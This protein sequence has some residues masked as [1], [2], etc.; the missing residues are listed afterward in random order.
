MKIL[1]LGKLGAGKSTLAYKINKELGLARL[2]LDEIVR[3]PDGGWYS[4]AEQQLKLHDFIINNNSWVMEGS[5]YRLYKDLTPDL[6]VYIDISRIKAV[7]RFTRRFFEAKK[8]LDMYD[9]SLLMHDRADEP[10]Q[11]YHYRK[12]T[13]SKIIDWDRCNVKITN[14]ANSYVKDASCKIIK[15]KNKNDYSK[16]FNALAEY[17]AQ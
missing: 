15:I 3:T 16:I 7:Y 8:L 2:N 17:G 6:V 1:I 12:P 9:G 14:D 10:V 11:P 5:A 4:E 13:L